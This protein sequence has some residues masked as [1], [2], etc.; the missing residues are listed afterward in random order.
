M[1]SLSP[2][3]KSDGTDPLRSSLT[4]LP[5]DEFNVSFASETS[6]FSLAHTSDDGG[7]QG[8]FFGF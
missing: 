6:E 8:S 3:G 5:V 7:G 4:L 2:I 1:L